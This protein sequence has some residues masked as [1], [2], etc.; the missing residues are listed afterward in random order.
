[1]LPMLPRSIKQRIAKARLRITPLCACAL[2]GV[3]AMASQGQNQSINQQLPRVQPPVRS[4][5]T[6][7]SS[8]SS[9]G[10]RVT[11]SSNESLIDYEA[12]RQGDKFYVRIP[13]ADVP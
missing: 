1:M 11:I 3:V 7:H 6:V 13:V 5:A 8:D 2:L 9:Q 4:I 12:Y 10:S